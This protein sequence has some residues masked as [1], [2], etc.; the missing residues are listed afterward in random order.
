M[1]YKNITFF[2]FNNIKHKRDFFF[3]QTYF[4]CFYYEEHKV[5][6]N[7]CQTN[8]LLLIILYVDYIIHT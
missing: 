7:G 2:V 5:F 1:F 4:F 6:K 3:G 8:P